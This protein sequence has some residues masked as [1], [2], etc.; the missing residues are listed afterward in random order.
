MRL[1][2]TPLARKW[3]PLGQHVAAA[4]GGARA[5][6]YGGAMASLSRRY[7]TIRYAP[8]LVIAVLALA[9]CA[10]ANR[11]RFPSLQRR[12][13]ERAYGT[14]LPVAVPNTGAEAAA[15][16]AGAGI[17]ARI[18]ALREQANE[19]HRAFSAQRAQTARL[20]A[21][22]RG[23][24]PG[25]DAWSAAQIAL[26]GLDS[27]RSRGMIAMADLD[28]MLI[29]ATEAA[30]TGGNADLMLVKPAHAE[31]QRMLSEENG[32]IAELRSGISG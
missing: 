24:T 28:R 20:A 17:A 10:S 27:A 29:A 5:P 1:M 30:V 18:A 12:A 3:L 16:P 9:G 26:A 11:S 21:T 7:C 31:V 8:A 4:S 32:A 13:A 15:L 6:C 23:A 22:A 25:S 14:V 2:S 19:A